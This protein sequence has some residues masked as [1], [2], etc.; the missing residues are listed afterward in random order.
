MKHNI[1][2]VGFRGASKIIFQKHSCVSLFLELFKNLNIHRLH[3]VNA[4]AKILVPS[5]P[6]YITELSYLY[7]QQLIGNYTKLE[8]PAFNRGGVG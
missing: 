6:T 5:R 1:S 3:V 8:N 4:Q 7:C 2:I